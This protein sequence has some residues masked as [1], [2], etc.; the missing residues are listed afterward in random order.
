MLGVVV[1]RPLR[2]LSIHGLRRWYLRQSLHTEDHLPD[3]QSRDASV[4]PHVLRTYTALLTY[5]ITDLRTHVLGVFVCLRKKW[6]DSNILLL[7]VNLLTIH[8]T[9]V[10]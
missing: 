3:K 9:S 4:Q 7:K 1:Q 8:N 5:L 6:Q 10:I 2:R